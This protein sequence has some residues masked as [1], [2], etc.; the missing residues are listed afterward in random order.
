MK[1]RRGG[2]THDGI[3]LF[4]YT[5][6]PQFCVV[7]GTRHTARALFGS[8]SNVMFLHIFFDQ[9]G[10]SRRGAAAVSERLTA[11][12][13]PHCHDGAT[14]IDGAHAAAMAGSNRSGKDFSFRDLPSG[15]YSR[16]VRLFLIPNY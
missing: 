16:D 3:F 7:S 9:A 4:L 12:R 5:L 1:R 11:A 6:A 8:R 13:S 10:P 14:M 15:A 2:E